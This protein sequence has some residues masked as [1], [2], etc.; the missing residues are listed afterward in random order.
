MT[1]WLMQAIIFAI[2]N[3]FIQPGTNTARGH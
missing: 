1:P 3:H 2:G